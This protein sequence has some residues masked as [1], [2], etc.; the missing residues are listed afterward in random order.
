MRTST[1][2]VGEPAVILLHCLKAESEYSLEVP[3]GSSAAGTDGKVVGMKRAWTPTLLAKTPGPQSQ[4]WLCCLHHLISWA[5]HSFCSRLQDACNCVAFLDFHSMKG[6]FIP[7]PSVPGELNTKGRKKC[8]GD[9]T[10][11][12]LHRPPLWSPVSIAFSPGE[13]PG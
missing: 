4:E 5:P 8:N 7:A 10:N 13:V 11:R 3:T 2:E 6:S 1:F 9:F 12:P